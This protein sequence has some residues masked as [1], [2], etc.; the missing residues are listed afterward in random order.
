MA[1]D[2]G[3]DTRFF[4]IEDL[5]NL[6]LIGRG[7]LLDVFQNSLSFYF[8]G[9]GST[10]ESPMRQEMHCLVG[11]VAREHHTAVRRRQHQMILCSRQAGFLDQHGAIVLAFQT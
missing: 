10:P 6:L 9:E 3:A 2:A 4:R 8:Q 1:A 5:E 11:D 7:I